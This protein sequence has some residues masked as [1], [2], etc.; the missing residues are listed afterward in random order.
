MLF[1]FFLNFIHN[2]CNAFQQSPALILLL[3]IYCFISLPVMSTEHRGMTRC[4]KTGHKPSEEG[5][6]RQPS[7][8]K[9]VLWPGKR[10]KDNPPDS[11]CLK[12]NKNHKLNHTAVCRGPRAEARKLYGCCFGLFEL[13]LSCLVDSVDYVLL[14]SSTSLA[15]IILPLSVL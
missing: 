6:A 11:L 14:V 12:S 5:R 9:N 2:S 4:I 13:L 10:V 8:R 7:M 15:P 1:S 3:P